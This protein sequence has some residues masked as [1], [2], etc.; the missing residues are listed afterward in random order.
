MNPSTPT[1]QLLARE[2]CQARHFSRKRLLDFFAYH[3]ETLTKRYMINLILCLQL[4]WKRNL[5]RLS[6]S[7]VPGSE[8]ET[9]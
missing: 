1:V 7:S 8:Q 6:K 2:N 3:D 4:K 5:L 9:P